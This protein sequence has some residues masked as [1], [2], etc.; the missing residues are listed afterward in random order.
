M[1][2]K[3]RAVNFLS[4]EQLVLKIVFY[5]HPF[6]GCKFKRAFGLLYPSSKRRIFLNRQDASS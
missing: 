6:Q 1:R 5:L 3:R 4:G 2:S